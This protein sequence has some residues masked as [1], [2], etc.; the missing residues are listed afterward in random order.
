MGWDAGATGGASA[1]YTTTKKEDSRK[2]INY[3]LEWVDVWKLDDDSGSW[4]G[5]NNLKCMYK[6]VED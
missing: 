6:S 3:I 5:M 2:Y 4:E 1:Y